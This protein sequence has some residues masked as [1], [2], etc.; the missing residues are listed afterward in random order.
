MLP[1]LVG[2]IPGG[3]GASS[4]RKWVS[5]RG[6]GPAPTSIDNIVSIVLVIIRFLPC[7]PENDPIT[8]VE[9][10]IRSHHDAPGDVNTLSRYAQR[11]ASAPGSDGLAVGAA[12][13]CVC[14]VGQLDA[15]DLGTFEARL[16][17]A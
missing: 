7:E 12:T 17:H 5:A 13:T 16:T 15:L 10:R 9:T 14:C 8:G 6:P 1:G 2:L 11:A 3:T 4:R